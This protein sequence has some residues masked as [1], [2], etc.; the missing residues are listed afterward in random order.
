MVKKIAKVLGALYLLFAAF[1]AGYFW[2]YYQDKAYPEVHVLT[3][4][5]LLETGSETPA[6]L[7][8]GTYLYHEK[9]LFH[10]EPAYYCVYLSVRRPLPLRVVD[11]PYLIAPLG[12]R[13]IPD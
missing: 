3:Q 2:H 11:K 12:T 8:A 7:P 5:L 10:T 4:P 6:I 13:F 1:G 9:R